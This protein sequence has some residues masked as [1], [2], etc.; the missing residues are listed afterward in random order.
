[1]GKCRTISRRVARS[2]A[3]A[4]ILSLG[5][6]STATPVLL[7]GGSLPTLQG[8][9]NTTAGYTGDITTDNKACRGS[10]TGTAGYP[11]VTL[12][13]SCV[14]GRSGIGT[15]TLADGVFVSGEV[16]LNDGTQLTVRQ[17][18]PAFP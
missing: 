5:A 18:A 4:S 17:H 10:F 2:I 7:Q 1:M 13:I 15:A 3:L 8:R 9:A 12:E 11:V 6:C 14:D 16:R